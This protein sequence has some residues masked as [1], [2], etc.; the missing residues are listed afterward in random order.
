[1]VS[2]ALE[3]LQSP[4]ICTE[5]GWYLHLLLRA[6]G[7]RP[8][9]TGDEAHA[10][11]QA[12]RRANLIGQVTRLERRR[13]DR[14]HYNPPCPSQSFIRSSAGS[15]SRRA[16]P[17]GIVSSWQ[18]LPSFLLYAPSTL[19]DDRERVFAFG[20]PSGNSQFRFTSVSSHPHPGI[21][22]GRRQQQEKGVCGATGRAEVPGSAH[23]P[24][25]QGSG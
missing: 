3:R 7:W 16:P 25:G 2:R 10:A 15:S 4:R 9:I 21:A 8:A 1:M 12:S 13:T 19:E 11:K 14:H 22:P 6:R 24:R 5:L 18:P 23:D 17:P 20:S